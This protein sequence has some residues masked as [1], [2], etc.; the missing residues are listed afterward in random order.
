MCPR[1]S[2]RGY[3]EQREEAEK[4]HLE[5]AV[6]KLSTKTT[7]RQWFV[8]A[9]DAMDDGKLRYWLLDSFQHLEWGLLGE[10]VGR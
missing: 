7:P 4:G 1:E 8:C 2:V 9:G 6:E 10:T 5:A 3:L